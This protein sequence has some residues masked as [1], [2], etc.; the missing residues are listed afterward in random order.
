MSVLAGDVG[1]RQGRGVERGHLYHHSGAGELH[2]AVLY[3]TVLYRTVQVLV[4]IQSLILVQ[5][6]YYNEP[7]YERN[8]GT[9]TGNRESH[10]YNEA[11]FRNNLRHAVLAQIRAPPEGFGHVT[12]SHFY[13]KRDTLIKVSP[14]NKLYFSP[15]VSASFND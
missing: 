3:C 10:S 12:R 7:G 6:P 9:A 8:Y 5:E 4:S 13:Y 1:Q 2:R 14:R 11:V 15:S